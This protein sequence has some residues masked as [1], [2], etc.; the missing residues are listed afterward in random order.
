MVDLKEMIKEEKI[1]EN[2]RFRRFLKM[3][4]DSDELD[5]QFKHL[6][7]QIFKKYDCVKC[8]NCCKAL[9]CE[10]SKEEVEGCAQTLDMQE[11]EFVSKYLEENI[12]GGFSSK[13]IPCV[14]LKDGKCLLNKNEPIS[15]KEYPYTDKPGRL[16]SLYGVIENAKIC[17]AVYEI[18]E[19]LKKIYN[20]K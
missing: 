18:L 6:H 12:D 4:A 7:N 13:K 20:F 9:G 5:R 11:I 16:F 1:D 15:C 17:P 19:E 8:R 10:I 14:F 2:L 3:R